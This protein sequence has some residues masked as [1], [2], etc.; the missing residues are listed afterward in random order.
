[1]S[2]HYET[3]APAI[4]PIRE[5]SLQF[6]VMGNENRCMS[7]EQVAKNAAVYEDYLSG[8]A[9]S[10]SI[11]VPIAGA[12]GCN[13]PVMPEYV[14]LSGW[15]DRSVSPTPFACI[16]CTFDVEARVFYFGSVEQAL[17]ESKRLAAHFEGTNWRV[18]IQL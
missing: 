11:G 15:P 4:N 6:A 12:A 10:A 16:E 8:R 14:P 1:M 3:A 17:D 5:R 2:S 9:S 18:F 7:A 13:S